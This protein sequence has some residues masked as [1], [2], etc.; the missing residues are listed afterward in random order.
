MHTVEQ[1]EAAIKALPPA[2][3]RRLASW[4]ADQAW[5]QWDEEFERDV[6]AG[7]L[8]ALADEALAEDAAGLT[9]PI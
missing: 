6:A 9:K 5:A 8:D 4:L 3:V 1:I 7:R 2:D